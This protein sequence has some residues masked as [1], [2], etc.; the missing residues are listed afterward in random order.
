[1][2]KALAGPGRDD[3]H[4]DI[5]YPATIPFLLAHLA[6]GAAVWT[7]VTSEA[8]VLGVALYV[9]RMFGICAGYHRYFSHR[10]FKTGRT[11]QFLL[12]ILAQSSAQRGVLWWAAK[13]RWHH[14]HSDTELDVHSPRQRGFLY[15]HLG[16]IFTPSHHETDY[17]A[18][19]DLA[20]FPELVWLD[21]H[22]YLPAALLGLA[23]WLIAGWS[24]L[25]VGFFWSTVAVWHATFSINSLAHVSGRRRYVTGDDSRNN[26]W[27]AILTMGEG[28][29]NNH[30]A[31]QSSARQGFRWWEFDPTFYI[32]KLLSWARIV[33]D[34]QAPP[35]T[36]LR[37]EQ[38]LGRTVIEKVAHQLAASFP[39]EHLAVQAR[40]ALEHTPTWAELHSRAQVACS[41]AASLLAECHL[42]DMPSFEEVRLYAQVRLVRTPS[43]D[44]VAER[45]HQVLLELVSARLLGK[46]ALTKHV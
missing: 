11:F 33:G 15:A 19:P 5:V 17:G 21:R 31:Y 35:A 38:R 14:K 6:C 10:A 39:V 4:E 29:H 3:Q 20:K 32:L 34:L 37:G 7:G 30:H 45:T 23:A 12:A 16:W 8:V 13:H 24:G 41:H 25:V 42:P 40:E 18:V 1:M 43:L 36:V 28:W 46:A 44:V 9:L 26:W 27:L 22:P 2:S